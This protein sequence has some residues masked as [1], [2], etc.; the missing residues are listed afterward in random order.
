MAKTHRQITDEPI[1]QIPRRVR[2]RDNRSSQRNA[3]REA[4]RSGDYSA[5]IAWEN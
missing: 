1:G 4:F 2:T 5:D 3:M